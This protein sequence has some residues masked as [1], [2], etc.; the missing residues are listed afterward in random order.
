MKITAG[1]PIALNN[2]D[3]GI[4]MTVTINGI[5]REGTITLS[6]WVD[7]YWRPNKDRTMCLSNEFMAACAAMRGDDYHLFNEMV[8]E[9][10][11]AIA[12]NKDVESE[13]SVAASAAVDTL[14]SRSLDA[15]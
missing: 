1:E 3:I 15:T 9:G 12:K 10:Q 8:L 4:P 7:G 2:G 11:V 6:R 5:T 13:A 14:H